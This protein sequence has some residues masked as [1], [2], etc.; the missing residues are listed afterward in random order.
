[1][2]PANGRKAVNI[3]TMGVCPGNPG[4]GGWGCVLKFG[5][6]RKELHGSLPD[7]TSDTAEIMAAISGLGA[8]KEICNVT[9]I[10]GSPRLVQAFREPS[11]MPSASGTLN[12]DLLKIL[13]FQTRKHHVT[14]V[15]ASGQNPDEESRRCADL[16]REA[17]EE[18]TQI[19]SPHDEDGNLIESTPEKKPGGT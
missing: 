10:T 14:F 13:F 9:L 2:M 6:H 3:Y 11:P 1:M 18:Y 5:E 12:P 4:P 19:N 16:A 8:L 17:V 7:T 15:L